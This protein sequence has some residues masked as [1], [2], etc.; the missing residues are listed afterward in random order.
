MTDEE[1]AELV[2]L[3]IDQDLPETLR[4]AVDE[5]LAKNPKLADD[6]VTL[7]ATVEELKALP[8]EKPDAWFVERALQG[9]LREHDAERHDVVL[10]H[11]KSA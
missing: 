7:R 3:S 4:R 1:I 2:G 6:A 9:L 11:L 10:R 5:A 8:A